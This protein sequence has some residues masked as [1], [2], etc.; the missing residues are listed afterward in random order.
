MKIFVSWSGELSH[1]I[2]LILK[3]WLPVMIQSLELYVSSEDIDKGTRWFADIGSELEDINFG[4]LCLTKDNK[5]APWILFEAGALA[6][7]INQSR[8]TPLLINLSASELQ[9]PLVQFQATTISKQ[10]MRKLLKAINKNLGN[11]GLEDSKIDKAF[12][13][14][15]PDLEQSF[16]SAITFA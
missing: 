11:Q 8:V 3:E 10:D 4:I 13:K 9:G 1:K 14:W 15:W 6:K 5:N 12:D 2:A 16:M 7:S